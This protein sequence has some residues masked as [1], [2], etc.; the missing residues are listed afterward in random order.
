MNDENAR[1]RTFAWSDP[2]PLTEAARALSGLAFFEKIERGELALPPI[3]E[4]FEIVPGSAA[5]GTIAFTMLPKEYM[6]N[7]IGTVH[8]GAIA[9]LLDS[10]IGC[11]V[12]TT[13]PVGRAYTTL[14]LVIRFLRPVTL[15]SGTLTAVGK[16]VHAG[17]KTASG[18]ATLHDANG[19]LC[20]TASSSCLL[21]DVA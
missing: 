14:D 18:E 5:H 3:L 7:P 20:A 9:T 21:I 16:V 12:H 17:R 6:Y 11:A 19:K 13:L 4:L 2:A 1:R 10:A 15:A 8:G